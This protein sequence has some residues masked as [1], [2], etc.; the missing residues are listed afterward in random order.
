MSSLQPRCDR[1][2]FS[3]LVAR[4]RAGLDRTLLGF[5]LLH[6]FR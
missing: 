2:L 5:D 1:G 4:V 6:N 3:D